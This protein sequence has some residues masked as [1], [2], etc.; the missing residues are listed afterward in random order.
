M[1]LGAG[2]ARGRPAG[3]LGFQAKM[4]YLRPLSALSALRKLRWGVIIKPT[5][6]NLLSLLYTLKRSSIVLDAQSAP[7][8]LRASLTLE[9]SSG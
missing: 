9:K 4:Y 7:H 6:A 1:P 3:R 8:V 2:R 5:N